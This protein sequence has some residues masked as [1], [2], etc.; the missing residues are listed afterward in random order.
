MTSTTKSATKSGRN[1]L[2]LP[3]GG[4]MLLA[5]AGLAAFMFS[6]AA[7]APS[8]QPISV[9][10]PLKAP[11][12]TTVKCLTVTVSAR[13]SAPSGDSGEPPGRGPYLTLFVATVRA[14]A[15][16]PDAEPVLILADEPGQAASELLSTNWQAYEELHRTR[17]L[18]FIDL[19]GTGRSQP[20]FAC[21]SLDPVKVRSGGVT[22]ADA[23]SCTEAFRQTGSG[24]EI[25]TTAAAAGD[26]IRLRKRLGIQAWSP[27]A[28]GYGALIALELLRHDAEG[29]R[30]LV[31]DSPVA[32]KAVPTD[33][34]RYATIQRVFRHVFADCKADAACSRDFP[35]LETTFDDLI[36]RAVAGALPVEL[37]S[38]AGQ[39]PVK[40]ELGAGDLL[41]MLTRMVGSGTE[42]RR[43]PALIQA[44]SDLAHGRARPGS[45]AAGDL[46]TTYR[47]L[48][49]PTAIGVAAAIMCSEVRPWVDLEGAR[50]MAGMFRPFVAPDSLI[51]P[52][53]AFCQTWKLRPVETPNAA[54]AEPRPVLILSGEYD[55]VAAGYQADALAEQVRGATLLRIRDLGHG[56]LATSKCARHTVAEFLDN[57]ER[58]SKA[59][60][61]GDAPVPAFAT[62]PAAPPEAAITLAAVSPP[63]PPPPS[64][65]P[66]ALLTLNV[67]ECPF[68][69]PT[70]NRV[71]CGTLAVP[72]RRDRPGGKTVSLFFAITR[73]NGAEPLPDPVLVLNGGPGQ[74][75]S[76]LIE[77]GWEKLAELRRTRDIIYVDQRGTG[78]SRPSLYCRNL[79][80]VAYWHGGLSAADAEACLKPIQSAGFDIANFNSTESAADLVALRTTLGIRKW[81]LFGTSY[82]TALAMEVV[83]RDG[84][85]V[86]SVVLN[87]PTTLRSSWLDTGR[88]AEIRDVYRRLF[89]D[90]AAD[91]ACNTAYPALDRV[92]LDLAKRMTDNPLPVSYLDPRTGQAVDTRMSFSN[93]LDILT[94]VVG[95]GTTAE[96]VPALLRHLSRVAEGREQARPELLSWLYMPYWQTMDMIAYGLN[97]AIGCREIRPWIDAA[98][99]RREGAAFEPYVFP[100]AVEQDYDV[101]CAAWRLP[102]SSEEVRQPVVS[103]VP[104]LL[105]T[106]DYDTMTPTGIADT[107][108]QN[109]KSAKVLRF[110]AIGHDVFSVSPCAR[111][112][113]TGFIQSPEQPIAPACLRA[114]R[115]P[116]F[117]PPR[118]S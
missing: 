3:A 53:E 5:A 13:L 79:S 14:G 80:P 58:H 35:A 85:A 40:A 23:A 28:G 37:P 11:A 71:D 44:L 101:F 41:R 99:L 4:A 57:P 86:R 83:R 59:A 100:Q 55:T 61:C 91:P 34:D 60:V 66:A 32:P 12:D 50:A 114:P 78:H 112:A 27:L 113:M 9:D 42:A 107:V 48:I 43:V 110:H 21:D 8:T 74:P 82:G 96:R 39:A 92:F 16:A 72:E 26:L 95:S 87:S 47:R 46:V 103:A 118:R 105:L 17:D 108:A 49:P 77:S 31:L 84:N 76:D 56:L 70:G 81:N 63:P 106:G 67:I 65:P 93:L 1:R 22:T 20:R 104:A 45:D 69:S 15:P 2:L 89:A 29:V 19:R 36:Q 88:M 18:I 62:R 102:R 33:L 116:V 24:P 52:F 51:L 117:V 64:T 97:A 115:A 25:F 10:C 68:A 109:L 75:G 73:A 6:G 54:V 98:R 94:V 111:E 38:A 30:S 90:C 7:P